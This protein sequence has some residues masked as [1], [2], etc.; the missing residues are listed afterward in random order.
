MPIYC[1]D[2]CT[3]GA[4]AMVGKTA[5]TLAQIKAVALTTVLV[6][7]VTVFLIIIKS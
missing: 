7:I 1:V 6:V 3:D 2:I 5:S 4:K